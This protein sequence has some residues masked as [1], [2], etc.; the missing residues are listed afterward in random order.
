M[1]KWLKEIGVDGWMDLANLVGVFAL[2]GF[3]LFALIIT[4]GCSSSNQTVE[5]LME[6]ND[7]LKVKLGQQDNL[8]QHYEDFRAAAIFIYI[9][10]VDS[11]GDGFSSSDEGCDFWRIDSAI[12]SIKRT[13]K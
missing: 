9:S 1:K 10:E 6:E 2:L 8:I 11:T 12:D 5:H 13:I 7:S 3:L 4:T